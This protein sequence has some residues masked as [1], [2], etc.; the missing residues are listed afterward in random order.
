MS[1][2]RRQHARLNAPQG[3]I[4]RRIGHRISNPAV[5]GSNPSGAKDDYHPID[6]IIQAKAAF[7]SLGDAIDTWRACLIQS[8]LQ[9]E[10][11]IGFEMAERS[12][13]QPFTRK[14]SLSHLVKSSVSRATR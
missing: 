1:K 5:E 8:V 14:N 2:E 9:A 3:A 4:G 11:R 12:S 6:T 7:Q 10:D 13:D